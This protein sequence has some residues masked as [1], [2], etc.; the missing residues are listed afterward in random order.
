MGRGKST[1]VEQ[2]L[3]L[4]EK[5]GGLRLR[6]TPPHEFA[7]LTAPQDSHGPLPYFLH[8]GSPRTPSRL[9][10]TNPSVPRRRVP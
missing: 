1:P 8:P 5:Q 6:T 7:P 3:L 9:L 2:G 4:D 10:L